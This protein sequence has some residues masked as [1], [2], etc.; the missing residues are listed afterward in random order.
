MYVL[1]KFSDSNTNPKL[2]RPI[3]RRSFMLRTT[4]RTKSNWRPSRWRQHPFGQSLYLHIGLKRNGAWEIWIHFFRWIIFNNL[5]VD[6]WLISC[7]IA[8]I[9][10]LLDLTKSTL[11]QAITRASVNPDLCRHI[12]SLGRNE[13][14]KHLQRTF[15]RILIYS[16]P[17][18]RVHSFI[19]TALWHYVCLLYATVYSETCL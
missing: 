8:L 1:C 12:A 11:V 2:W 3:V 17:A 7:E 15:I 6:D 9:W 5:V 4:G 14:T 16:I 10:I 13:L 19:M 18:F